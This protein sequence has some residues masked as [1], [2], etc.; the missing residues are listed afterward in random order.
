[1]KTSMEI[2]LKG[3]IDGLR[4]GE[5]RDQMLCVLLTAVNCAVD[6]IEYTKPIRAGHARPMEWD[7]SAFVYARDIANFLSKYRAKE[8]K[9]NRYPIIKEY[10]MYDITNWPD[11]AITIRGEMA[12]M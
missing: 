3:T 6:L 12:D 2:E 5:D 7:N 1:M 4:D 10:P 11:F 8:L 9:L